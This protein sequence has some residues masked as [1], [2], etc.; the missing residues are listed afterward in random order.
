MGQLLR[1]AWAEAQC[2]L[3]AALFFVGLGLV[4]VV[5]LPL[6]PA[7]A[8]LLWSPG[9]TLVLWLTHWETGR[10]PP[11]SRRTCGCS[12]PWRSWW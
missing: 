7:D 3:S 6:S 8:L 2:C 9:V 12:W 1:F 10:E 11:T 5:P 4:R